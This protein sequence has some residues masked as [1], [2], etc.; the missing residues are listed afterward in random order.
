MYLCTPAFFWEFFSGEG[1]KSIVMQISI[2][3]LIFLLFSD[4]ISAG[5]KVSEGGKLLEGEPPPLWKNASPVTC[6]NFVN[7]FCCNTW[8]I[9]EK[10]QSSLFY[11]LR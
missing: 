9:G 10:I 11:C 2:V 5:A 7:L 4:Q 3:M 6:C 1:A 8:V